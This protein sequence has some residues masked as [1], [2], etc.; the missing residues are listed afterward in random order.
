[1]ARGFWI[2]NTIASRIYHDLANYSLNFYFWQWISRTCK[3]DAICPILLNC[4]KFALARGFWDFKNF[5]RTCFF[6]TNLT[7]LLSKWGILQQ[8]CKLR[9]QLLKIQ[10]LGNKLL[11]SYKFKGQMCK[12]PEGF[13]RCSTITLL[14]GE[15]ND[16]VLWG[17]LL[18]GPVYQSLK[19]YNGRGN[20]NRKKKKK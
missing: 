13:L 15:S 10:N 17:E 16:S 9:E 11:K 2:F 14:Q 5:R 18:S 7:Q 1:M 12:I 20:R 4:T 8:V 6:N 19:K 3:N